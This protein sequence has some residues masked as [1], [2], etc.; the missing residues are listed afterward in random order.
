MCAAHGA[1]RLPSA[2]PALTSRRARCQLR[3]W[4]Q[5][6]GSEDLQACSFSPPRPTQCPQPDA[7]G[8]LASGGSP[9]VRSARRHPEP[10]LWASPGPEVIPAVTSQNTGQ[11]RG[12][13]ER[14]DPHISADL[15]FPQMVKQ[16]LTCVNHWAINSQSNQTNFSLTTYPIISSFHHICFLEEHVIDTFS[17]NKAL[18]PIECFLYKICNLFPSYTLLVII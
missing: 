15:P 2:L 5:G 13:G 1:S 3:G 18:F 10:A 14:A 11:S 4:E 12:R 9:R 6:G 16:C 8:T 17:G 7:A